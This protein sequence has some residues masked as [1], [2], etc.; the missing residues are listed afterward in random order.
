MIIGQSRASAAGSP[1]TLTGLIGWWDASVFASLNLTGSTVNSIADQS[2]NSNTMTSLGV[3]AH[4][5]YS[6]TGFN[7][8]PAM[9]FVRASAQALACDPFAMGTSN[10]LT[11]FFVATM[12][13]NT[14]SSGRPVS[15]TRPLLGSHDFTNEGSW[16][17]ERDGTNDAV[18]ITSN[19]NLARTD[20]ISLSTPYRFIATRHSGGTVT[21]YV[22]GVAGAVTGTFTGVWEDAGTAALGRGKNDP[23]YWDGAI[24]EVGIATGYS[25][26]TAVAALDTYLKNKWGL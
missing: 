14:Q 19:G 11:V 16:D 9:V 3:I 21:F 15:Y 2:G 1:P 12:T 13:T 20:A 17:V 7:S 24:G 22:D 25:D 6:A 5:T 8:K 26:A 18:Q 10:T 23:N 4:P